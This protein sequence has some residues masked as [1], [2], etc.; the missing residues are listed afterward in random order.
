ME[1]KMLK[2]GYELAEIEITNFALSDVIA[3][4]SSPEWDDGV[5]DDGWTD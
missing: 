3:T 1:K 4:S 2:L 5:S